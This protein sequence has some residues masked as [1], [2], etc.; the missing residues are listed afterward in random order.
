M[1]LISSCC[2]SPYL[3][4]RIRL[5]FFFFLSSS[6]RYT[7][8]QCYKKHVQMHNRKQMEMGMEMEYVLIRI[9]SNENKYA[10]YLLRN[11]VRYEMA[12]TPNTIH[13]PPS[14]YLR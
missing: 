11:R 2:Y 12:L 4:R 6:L 1:N 10:L 9:D 3:T 13:H 14:F 8:S 7:A 5:F